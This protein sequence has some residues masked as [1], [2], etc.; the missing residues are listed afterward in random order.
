MIKQAEFVTSVVSV[1]DLPNDNFD[2]FLLLGRSNVGKS[3][4]INAV[5]NRKGL[6]RVSQTPG[7]TI[8]LNLYLLNESLYLVDAPGYGYAKRS[9]TQSL[10]FLK[11]IKEYIKYNGHLKKIILLIDFNVGPTID[12]LNLYIELQKIDI[13]LII[14]ATKYDKVKSS[15]RMKQQ[16]IIESKF[17]DGQKMY[18]TSSATKY[19]IEKLINE[20]FMNE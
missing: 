4:L 18:I 6:A 13:E 19:G 2:H 1:A 7:K 14:V 5:T 17:F 11:M 16:K 9:K 15:Y 8:T 12:D 20:V 10:S 3:S